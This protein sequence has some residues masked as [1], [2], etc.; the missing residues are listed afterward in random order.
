MT[1]TAGF[2]FRES[3]GL[4]FMDASGL[5]GR[6]AAMGDIFYFSSLASSFWSMSRV[7]ASR[8]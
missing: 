7:M 6:A 1:E 5:V 4:L 2:L 8:S 3:G